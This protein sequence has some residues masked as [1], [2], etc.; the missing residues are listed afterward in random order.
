MLG[1]RLVVERVD[2]GV[3]GIAVE[4]DRLREGAVRLETDGGRA[5]F[6]R[7]LLQAGEEPPPESEP[8]RV[9]RDPHALQLGGLAPV[10]LQGTAAHGLLAAARDQ[11]QAGRRSEIL[12]RCRDAAR[13]IESGLEA[14]RKLREVLLDAPARVARRGILGSDRHE[15]RQQEPL[16]GLHRRHQDRTPVLVERLE[17][18]QGQRVRQPVELGALGRARLAQASTPHPAVARSGLDDDQPRGLERAQQPARIP[19][20][21]AQPAA[22][23]AHLGAVGADLPQHARLSDGPA[24]TEE[25]LVERAHALGDHAIEGAHARHHRAAHSLTIVR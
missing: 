4:G 22:E 12:G 18:R 24:A 13:R 20:I 6:G 10:E 9:G 14:R 25:L 23:L 16:D 17:H 15:R 21:H 8:A 2:L 7:G 1:V 3:P 11:Q 19:G 5:G